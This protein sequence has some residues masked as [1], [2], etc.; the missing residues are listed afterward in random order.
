MKE[1]ITTTAEENAM[2]M[3]TIQ[4]ELRTSNAHTNAI[5][6]MLSKLTSSTHVPQPTYF[7][8]LRAYPKRAYPPPLYLPHGP[9]PRVPSY[10]GTPNTHQLQLPY[11][12]PMIMSLWPCMRTKIYECVFVNPLVQ[13]PL[14]LHH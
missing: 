12:H 6:A 2:K 1:E 14:T 3:A 11:R 4:E 5:L 7:F 8:H 13:R 9:Y 10:H